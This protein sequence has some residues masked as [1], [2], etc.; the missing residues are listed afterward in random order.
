MSKYINEDAEKLTKYFKEFELKNIFLNSE[1][2]DEFKKVHKKTLG[3]L[4]IYFEIEKQNK[5]SKFFQEKA[6]YYLKESV[7]DILQSF[8]CW[9]NGAYKASDLFLR[10]SIENFNKAIIG[11]IND[12]VYTEKSVYKIFDMANKLDE[13]KILIG[14]ESLSVLLHRIYGEL[15]KSTHTATNDNMKH[16]TAL[17]LLPKY[18]K[19]KTLKFR[20]N[21]ELLIDAYLGYFLA[22]NRKIVDG[23]F[24]ENV[25]I[26]YE[27]LSKNVIRSVVNSV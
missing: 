26:F 27:V 12:D 22:N 2:V 9:I 24:R 13:Y 21:L 15:C 5:R 19:E 6:I 20:K 3:Y 23:M 10:S 4:V 17:N 7:S 16:I 1:F 14:K 11:N 18:E 25:D 8:F